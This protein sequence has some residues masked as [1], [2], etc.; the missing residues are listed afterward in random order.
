MGATSLLASVT[1]AAT[2]VMRTDDGD[3]GSISGLLSTPI[4]AVSRLIRPPPTMEKAK[5][6]DVASRVLFPMVF[7]IFNVAYWTNY[8]LQAAAEIEKTQKTAS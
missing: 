4:S 5:R 6:I 1:P 7:A 3:R 8:L 2:S